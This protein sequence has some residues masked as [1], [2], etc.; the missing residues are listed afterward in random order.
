MHAPHRR[1]FYATALAVGLSAIAATTAT[2]RRPQVSPPTHQN[3]PTLVAAAERAFPPP[4]LTTPGPDGKPRTLS[5]SRVD[6][7]VTVSGPLAQTTLTLTFR[8]DTDR[9]LEGELNLPLPEGAAITGYGLDVGGQLVD[10]VPVEKQKAR[11]TFE[12]ETRRNVDPGLAEEVVGNNFRT[13]VYPIPAQGTRTVRV[14][15]VAD[16]L[17]TG[18]GGG[19]TYAVPLRW[20]QQVPVVTVG[21][22]VF[23]GGG[24]VSDPPPAL[25]F[26]AGRVFACEPRSGSR[27]AVERTLRGETLANDLLVSVPPTAAAAP[28]ARGT[29]ERFAGASG[30][31]PGYFFALRDVVNS[32]PSDVSAAAASPLAGRRVG[33]VWDASLSRRGADL[34]RERATLA[35]ALRR[36]G[37]VDVDLVVLRD[38]AEAPRSF[39]VRGGDAGALLRFLSALP[40]DGGTDLGALRLVRNRAS[41]AR[42]KSNGAAAPDYA[43]WLVFSDGLGSLGTAPANASSPVPVWAF[44]ADPRANH[45]LLRRLAERS[46]GGAYVNLTRLHDVRA[47]ASVIAARPFSLL[48]ISPVSGRVADVYPAGAHPVTGRPLVT[49]RL[50]SDTAT[51]ALNYGYAGSGRVSMRRLVSLPRADAAN[52]TGLVA[53]YWARQHA[54]ALAADPERNR[55]ALLALGREFNVVT[56]NTSLL[57]LET[58]EQHLEHGIAPPRSRPTLYAAYH[59]RR[60]AQ[61]KSAQ[62]HQGDKLRQVLAQWRERVAWW[63]ARHERK[64]RPRELSVGQGAVRAEARGFQTELRVTAR[65]AEAGIPAYRQVPATSNAGVPGGAVRQRLA[66]PASAAP[67]GES[68]AMGSTG[69]VRTLGR[70]LSVQGGSRA[71]AVATRVEFGAR[72]DAN[73]SGGEHPGGATIAVRAWS[74]NTPYLRAL[75]AAGTNGAY[76]AYLAQRDRAGYGDSPAFYLDCAQF[77]LGRGQTALGVRVLTDIAELQLEDAQ[78]LRIVAHRLAQ[79]GRRDLALTIFEHVKALRPEE[80]QSWRDLALVLADR[81]DYRS[82]HGGSPRAALADYNRSLALLYRVV[83]GNWDRFDGIEV[84]ALTEANRVIARARRLPASVGRLAVP[85]DSRLV[86][87]LP[88]GVRVAMTWDTDD[89]DMDLW[90]TE[91]TGEK[92]FYSNPQTG[93][94]GHLSRD[95][96]QGYGPEE[97]LLRRKQTGR[98]RIQTNFYGSQSQKLT[99]GTTVQATVFTDWGLPT[100]K[101]QYLTLRLSQAKDTV[102]IGAVTVGRSR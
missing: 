48:R 3:S 2:A 68:R 85:F 69:G 25:R 13:R 73:E 91:P 21:L 65:S 57:V 26:G 71:S 72:A 86:R 60:G 10:G 20:G 94:G 45:A 59:A 7:R 101:R 30:G 6:A 16:L 39:T 52:A 83:M 90:V 92:C 41:L 66:R 22:E 99:G 37:N 80:P 23:P 76:A 62:R 70:V 43:A 82:V 96:T 84:I 9:I 47:A 46:T 31:G 1:L 38:V 74:P 97:Y 29:V 14:R 40:Y 95:F 79:L 87:N 36:A 78:L 34:R 54:D 32:P 58:L 89:T 17:T 28:R 27:Y 42:G 53:R 5:L 64:P 44:S 75:R 56:P 18:P 93:I 12:K 50:L 100:E 88:C 102:E 15:Y 24:T 11:V 61:A 8:N 19:A 4:R 67:P 63:E 35:E 55:G 49:G 33:V 98:Y 51:L 77:L 81:A